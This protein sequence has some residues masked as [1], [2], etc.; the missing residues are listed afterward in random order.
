M[1]FKSKFFPKLQ[2]PATIRL[3]AL[4][5][6]NLQAASILYSTKIQHASSIRRIN[7]M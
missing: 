2:P 3:K 7:P 1:V 5:I 6:I 4:L